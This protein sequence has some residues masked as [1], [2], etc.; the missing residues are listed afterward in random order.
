LG[1]RARDIVGA[2]AAQ[3]GSVKRLA[4][5]APVRTATI[6]AIVRMVGVNRNRLT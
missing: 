2:M 6:Q 1:Q 3:A 4:L 5:G